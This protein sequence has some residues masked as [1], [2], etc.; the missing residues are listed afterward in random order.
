MD[1]E[2]IVWS[3]TL[4]SSYR[5]F[6]PLCNALDKNVMEYSLKTGVSNNTYMLATTIIKIIGRKKFIINE[7]IFIDGILYRLPSDAARLLTVRYI[8]GVKTELCSKTLG[9]SQ[10]TFFRHLTKSLDLFA[11]EISRQGYT[12]SMLKKVFENE[13]WV[14]DI[15]ETYKSKNE[16]CDYLNLALSSTKR[17]RVRLVEGFWQKK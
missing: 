7:K 16:D 5:C 17:K 2:L 11:Q 1:T 9:I 10:R 14:L 3:K 6:E 8:D 13:S 12:S 4:L 15:F